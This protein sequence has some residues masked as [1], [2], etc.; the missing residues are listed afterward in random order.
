[1]R[2]VAFTVAQHAHL[3][4][5][6]PAD[7]KIRDRLSHLERLVHPTFIGEDD[8]LV[9]MST[10]G[11][12]RAADW[13]VV[14]GGSVEDAV[15]LLRTGQQIDVLFTD[16]GLAAGLTSWDV[17]EAADARHLYLW[18]LRRSLPASSG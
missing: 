18:Q 8:A 3:F 1:M 5:A 9:R 10:A 17:A 4:C 14:E 16:I 2:K 12:P 7:G 6:H 13:E 15:R 11:E